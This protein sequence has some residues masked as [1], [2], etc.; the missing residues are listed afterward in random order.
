[1]PLLGGG[2]VSGV[3]YAGDR[4]SRGRVSG[5]GYKGDRLSREGRASREV[6]PH[7]LPPGVE[8]TSAVGRH[9]SGMLYCYNCLHY[10]QC[11]S[12]YHIH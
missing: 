5:V 8:A 10:L 6:F 7:P 11:Q 1:M 3:V 2:K 4:V 12:T 9:R